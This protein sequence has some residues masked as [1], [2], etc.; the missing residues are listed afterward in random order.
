LSASDALLIFL[1]ARND[2]EG[3]L[4]LREGADAAHGAELEGLPP[5]VDPETR[6]ALPLIAVVPGEAVTLHWLEVPAGLAPA[7]AV[8]AARLMASEMSTQPL[9]DMHVAVGREAEG[10]TAR[11][12]ALVPAIT[13]AGWI[14]RLQAQGLDPDLVLPEPLLLPRPAE[15]FLR[16]DHGPLPIF[17]GPNDAF[18]VE[19]ELAD[20]ILGG[21]NVETID[22]ATFRTG[23]S[24]AI[25]H[26]PVNLRQGPFAK[27]R[28]WQIQWKLIRRLALLGVAIVMVTLAIQVTSIMRYTFAADALELE[29]QRIASRALPGTV[30]VT[31]APEQ[32]ERRL[33]D[34]GGGVGYSAIASAV[35]S[36]VG[37]TPNA[38]MTGLVYD[39][40]GNLRAT[41]QGDSPA[42]ITALQD[43]IRSS[44]FAV[45]A[46][47]IRTGGGRPTMELTVRAQ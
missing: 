35:F 32:L 26:P 29:A 41:V 46:G 36:A 24:N 10:E 22:A 9:V 17:R 7:Q 3:W 4:H 19:P 11:A 39:I 47:S 45:E 20:L 34:L 21:A 12:V 25:A 2:F 33:A 16:Y 14:G 18:T 43:R 5:L 42:T 28:R 13:M 1:D 40:D 37:A 6:K 38:E 30:Q 31:N 44:G 27:R 15:G 23:I 8:A